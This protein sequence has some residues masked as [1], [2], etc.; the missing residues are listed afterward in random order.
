MASLSEVKLKKTNIDTGRY[1]ELSPKIWKEISQISPLLKDANIIHINATPQGGGVAEL[2]KSEII[3]ERFFGLKSRWFVIDGAPSNFFDV[4]KKI[5][6][7]LQGKG[8]MLTRKEQDVYLKVNEELD[9]SFQKIIQKYKSATVVIH[10]PQPLPL[11]NFIDGKCFPVL[12]LHIDL[13]TPNPHVID[14]LKP[15]IKK[16]PLVV[17][18]H[19]AYYP[20]L[21]WINNKKINIIP[22]AIDPLTEKNVPLNIKLAENIITKFNIDCSRPILTQI[23][24]F[25]PW[26]DPLGVIESY[27]LAKNKIP[28]L[29]LIL[30]GFFQAKDDPEAIAVFKKV[31][32]AKNNDKDIH[33]FENLR[34]LGKINNDTFIK[35]LLTASSLIMQKSLREGFGLTVTE[36]MWKKKTVI[37]GITNGTLLQIKNKKNGILISSAQEASRAI[38]RLLK[39]KKMSAHIGRAAHLSVKNNFLLPRFIRDNLMIY[40]K[41]RQSLSVK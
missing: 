11:I 17:I 1:K 29:Q 30:A 28:E 6:N 31:K 22:P 15:L 20:T 36:A 33:L 2:L 25:D 10:D 3:F 12:R 21:S 40:I 5:H 19:P 41:S 8:G 18:S 24:R 37:A 26:K 7:L 27:R 23:S 35:A 39:N 16:Y 14:F 4:T 34:V 32:K 9:K 13:S 38:I